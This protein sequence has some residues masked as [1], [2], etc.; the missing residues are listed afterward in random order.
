M[1]QFI[2]DYVSSCQQCSRNNNIF[3]K[4]FGLLKPLPIPN[5]PWICLSMDFI[6]KL[7]LSDS[8]DSILVIGD[9]F[10][11]MAVFIPTMSS[12]TSLDLANLLIKNFFSKNGLPSSIKLKISTHLSTAYHPETYGQAERLNQILEQYLWMYVTYHQ[13]YWNT[14][15]PLP[16]FAYNTSD[17]SSTKQSPFFTAY[18]RVPQF[19]S[20]N[21]TQ[22]TP[23]GK[24]STKI[25]SVQQDFKRELEVAI[26][27]FKR[28]SN[29]QDPPKGCLKYGW[30][31]FNLQE[32][33]YSCLSPQASI[34]QVF[35]MS[36]LEPV[37]TL[38]IPNP[39]QEHPPP[40]II[41]EQE[42]WEVFQI[43][44]SKFKRRKSWYLA[45]YGL[46]GPWSVEP[47]G[48][49]W[50]KSNEAKRNQEG[51]SSAPK[52]RWV[53]NHNWAH[54][55]QFWHQNPTNPEIAKTTLGPETGQRKV[56]KIQHI[57]SGNHQRPP[58]Q[59]QAKIPSH[60]RIQEWCIY[61]IMYHY[62]PFLLSNPIVTF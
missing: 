27:R 54:L 8:F 7:T 61:G 42:E 19:D 13:D 47:L 16:E 59:I 26:N 18:G 48:P 36:L 24:L 53:P 4:K 6:T 1:T 49:F 32:N 40:I 51:N 30:L 62:A 3:H 43:L 12:I 60:S 38:T 56:A 39:H 45:P 14:W 41:E 2:K 52:A 57:A 31:L 28:T 23:A 22:T 21:I 15:L 25:Q 9:R 34:Y 46:Y 37:K 33:Q 50:P 20:A 5:G 17:Q 55:S 29:Q 44:D 35:Q 58:T 11:K 10:S